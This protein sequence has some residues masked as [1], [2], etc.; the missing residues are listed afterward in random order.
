MHRWCFKRRS[1]DATK[2]RCFFY[3]CKSFRI[4]LIISHLSIPFAFCTESKNPVSKDERLLKH[5][6]TINMLIA[7]L[8]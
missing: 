8:L 4:V 5:L 6:V 2:I 3:L 7:N 1:S